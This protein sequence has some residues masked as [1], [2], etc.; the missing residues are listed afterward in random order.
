MPGM[1]MKFGWLDGQS[2]QTHQ[3]ADGGHVE[4][5]TNSRSSVGRIRGDDAAARV[6][7]GPLGFPDHLRGAADLAGVAFG[8]DLVAGQMNRCRPACN[9]LRLE[10]VLRDIHQHRTGTSAGGDVKRFVNDLRQ[11][12]D[13]L[14]HEVVLGGRSA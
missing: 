12:G 10:D 8:E 2:A 1:L 6:N 3:R 11:F 13:V 4:S 5:S 7:E 14:H 9:G